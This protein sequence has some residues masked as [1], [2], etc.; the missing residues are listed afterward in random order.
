MVSYFVRYRG[1]SPDPRAFSEYYAT[2][3]ASILRGFGNIRSLVLHQ[4]AE[5][6]DPFPVVRGETLLLAQMA[7]D[8]TKDLDEALQLDARRQA[9][10]D[11]LR[12]PKFVGEVTHEAMSGKV[13]F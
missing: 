2:Q 10:E 4:P 13:I 3:H 6:A 8:S 9:R 1:T 7:F 12:F 5:W 11:F